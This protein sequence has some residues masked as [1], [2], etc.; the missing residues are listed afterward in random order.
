MGMFEQSL[1][2]DPTATRKTGALAASLTL[3]TI[4]V[5]AIIA[6]P[7][8][9]GD[10]LPDVRPYISLAL[11]I[12]TLPPEPMPAR[13]APS[14]STS[15]RASTGPSRPFPAPARI[16]SLSE[17]PTIGVEEAPALSSGGNA[18]GDPL[19][20]MSALPSFGAIF[21][22]PPPKPKPAAETKQPDK[23]LRLGGEVLAAKLVKKVIP[24][25]PSLARQVRI[26]GKVELLGVIA[27]DGTIQHLQVVS[28]HPLLVQAALEAVRQWIYSPTLLNGQAMEVIAPISVNFTLAQ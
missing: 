10:R 18:V 12:T 25:Y 7:L 19:G 28:G 15:T 11:P 2:L 26:S 1:L 4:A 24:V 8:I 5:G 16:V 23:P 17:I 22:D 20:A 13:A 3:Q 27:R 6:I 14:S 9:W 21:H